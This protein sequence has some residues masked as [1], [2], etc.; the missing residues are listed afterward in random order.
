MMLVAQLGIRNRSTWAV[1]VKHVAVLKGIEVTNETENYG[2]N[3]GAQ[4]A[5][6]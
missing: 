3:R 5:P 6:C 2:Y 4:N 1:R